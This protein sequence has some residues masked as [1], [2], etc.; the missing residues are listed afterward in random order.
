LPGG[1]WQES[2]TG[3]AV[4]SLTDPKKLEEYL[5]TSRVTLVGTETLEGTQAR[6][7][8]ASAP[9]SPARKSVHDDPDPFLMKVWVG[10]SDNLPRRLEGTVLSTKSKTSVA[11]YDFGAKLSVKKPTARQ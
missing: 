6:V 3:L 8:Q 10:A 2:P 9:R 5:K 7:Y 1:G 11:F 4:T